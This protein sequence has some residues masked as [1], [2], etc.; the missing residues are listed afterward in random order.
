[1]WPSAYSY[2]VGVPKRGSFAAEYPAC[3]YPCQ[4]FADGRMTRGRCGS[5]A[6]HRTTLSF[7]TPR[8]FNPAHRSH[9]MKEPIIVRLEDTEPVSFGPLSQY[10]LIIGDDEGTT[11]VRTG[12]QTA[13]PGYVAPVHQHPY[14]EI[15]Q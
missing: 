11:P 4:R 8:R 2:G 7:A 9:A 5:L 14:V 6:L 1:M 10:Q 3:P 12:I 13:Q 15:L